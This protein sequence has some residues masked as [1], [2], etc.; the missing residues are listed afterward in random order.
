MTHKSIDIRVG[1]IVRLVSKRGRAG[2]FALRGSGVG[3][4]PISFMMRASDVALVVDAVD[5]SPYDHESQLI[6]FFVGGTFGWRR[7]LIGGSLR[8]LEIVSKTVQTAA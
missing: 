6:C 4:G 8:E 2:I 1:D 3:V 7:W 5:D